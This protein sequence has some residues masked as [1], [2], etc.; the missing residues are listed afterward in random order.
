M[1]GAGDLR[2]R[3]TIRRQIN[4]KNPETGGLTRE[5]STIATVWAEVK[6]LNGREALIGDVLQGVASFQ[7]RIR[8]RADILAADQLLWGDRELNVHSAEDRSGLKTWLWIVASTQA[9]QGA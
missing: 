6:S 2:E 8:H 9:P 4:T 5:W 1:S 7:V 3:V